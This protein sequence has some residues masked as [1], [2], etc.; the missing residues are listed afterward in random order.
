VVVVVV[1]KGRREGEEWVDGVGGRENTWGWNC[2]THLLGLIVKELLCGL[3]LGLGE[4]IGIRLDITWDL[5][6]K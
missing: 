3:S 1:V 4:G 6:V 2:R 5:L